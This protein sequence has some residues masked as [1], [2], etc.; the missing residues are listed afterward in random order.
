MERESYKERYFRRVMCNLKDTIKV[1]V[2][3]V[4]QKVLSE[5]NCRR[6]VFTEV[7]VLTM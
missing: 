5:F 6:V 1:N 4:T 2:T 7:A 3:Q